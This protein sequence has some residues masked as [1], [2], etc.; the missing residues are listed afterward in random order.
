[1]DFNVTLEPTELSA[2]LA[3]VSAFLFALSIQVQNVGLKHADPRSGAL[4]NIGATA[5]LYWLLSPFFVEQAYW[6]T[7]ATALF[8]LVGLFRPALSANLAVAGVKM[9][10]PTLTSGLP[11]TAPIFSA[12]FAIL[13]LGEKMTL[14]IA[15]GTAFVVAGAAVAALRSGGLTRGWPVWAIGLPLG[16]AFFRA[17]GHPI[18]ISG[19]A[20][21]PSPFFAGMVSYTVSLIIVYG[22]FRLQDRRMPKLKT[23]YGWFAVA[24]ILNGVSIYSLNTALK[25]GNL[26]TVAPI[27]ACSPVFTILMGLLIFKREKITWRSAASIALVVFGVVVVV[28]RSCRG[29]QGTE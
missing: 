8:A 13:L 7:S 28:M 11:A 1:M 10:G 22:T 2:L 27:V 25:I 26:L 19:F 16:A 15:I 3:A 29:R 6:L 9:M 12:G 5:L 4:V 24:G 20:E 21:V 23:G 18:T 14:P 17:V